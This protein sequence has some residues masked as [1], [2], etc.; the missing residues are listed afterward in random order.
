MKKLG[1]FLLALALAVS[2][3][4]A[5]LAAEPV[6]PTP[7]EWINAEDYLTFPGDEVYLPENWA[8]VEA[9][10]EEARNGALL[11]IDGSQDG[12]EGSPGMCYE[13]GL[14]RIKYGL[15]AGIEQGDKNGRKAFYS[16]GRAFQAAQEDDWGTY[17]KEHDELYHRLQVETY[18]AWAIFS[19]TYASNYKLTLL[20]SLYALN[21]TAD[22]FFAGQYMYL[23]P[24]ERKANITAELNTIE[25][26]LDG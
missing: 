6:T 9:L 24:A 10:R 22:D 25:L 12:A 8:K 19:S 14:V 23:V 5:A 17:G 26:L 20:P 3:V 1:A 21:M 7:P 13:T 16:A 4:P 11:V 18:R 15:N 2:L